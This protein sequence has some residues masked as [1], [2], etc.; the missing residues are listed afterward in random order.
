MWCGGRRKRH[1]HPSTQ[2]A[3]GASDGNVDADAAAVQ[4]FSRVLEKERNG[5]FLGKTVQVIPHVTNEIQD[6]IIRV[7][8]KPADGSAMAPEICVIELGGTGLL[9]LCVCPC[10]PTHFFGERKPL[11]RKRDR[12]VI[13][14]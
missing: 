1:V 6:W 13:D 5:E 9:C 3:H 8:K 12:L 14:V 10:V 4:I 2:S 11:F 7:A